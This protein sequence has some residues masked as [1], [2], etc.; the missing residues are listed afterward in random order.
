MKSPV[1]GR[2]HSYETLGTVDGP[3]L[4]IVVFLQG[5]HLRCLYCHNPDTWNRQEGKEVYSDKL[6]EM[7]LQYKNFIRTGGVTLSGGEPLL[8]P[9]FCEDVFLRLKRE[10]IHSALDTCG[11]IPLDSCQSAVDAADM[12][13]LDIKA[14]DHAL[15]KTVTGRDN[16]HTLSLLDHC[17]AIGKPVWI[18]HVLLPGYTL[19]KDKLEEM[20]DFL[21]RYRCIERVELLPFHKMG[22]YKWKELGIPYK[23]EHV[24]EPSGYEV[25]Q[26]KEI[27]R[28]YGLACD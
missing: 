10:K 5:C 22:E 1:A 4:R 3:G 17:E 12:I 27:F 14:L 6:V 16:T 28:R 18:R 15:C 7:I 13:L 26:A 9:D 19:D 8:Q 25:S 23:L 20:G 21:S 11:A 2:I 24:E